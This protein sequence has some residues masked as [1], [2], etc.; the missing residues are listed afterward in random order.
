MKTK[1]LIAGLV[2]AVAFASM[3]VSV[4]ASA[5][6][7]SV[8]I[9][10]AEVEAGS[11]FT[12]SV[13]LENIPAAGINGCEFGITY[14]SSVVTV[15]SVE[16]GDLAKDVTKDEDTLPPPLEVNIEK[17]VISLM[18]ALG[19]IDSKLY[20]SGSGT[21]LNIKGEVKDTAKAGDKSVF[22]IVAVDRAV[23]PG[24]T[25]SNTDIVFG[26]VS[27]DD[28]VKMYTPTFTSGTVTV[29]GGSVETTKPTTTETPKTSD[30][31]SGV[32]T[33]P[34][35]SDN[36]GNGTTAPTTS[37]N[38]GDGTTAPGTTAKTTAKTTNGDTKPV[39]T[40]DI[41]D[42]KLYGDVNLD[43][44]VDVSDVVALNLYLLNSEKY[45]LTMEAVAN[46]DCQRDNAI[47]PVDSAVLMNAVV[48]LTDVKDLGKK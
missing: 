17:D 47:T 11:E 36:K 43:G 39:T 1:K 19:T 16:L 35:T 30:N 41:P 31:G 21:F 22:E 27:D 46:A 33:A 42:G 6:D 48:E 26:Y 8:K 13:D 18:Y 9:S 29:K 23:T 28:S 37:D 7:L 12:L 44:S 2:S 34:T 3:T 40:I 25:T 14:D 10:S 24:S 5:A 15:S 4:I 20:L 45:P 32:N 38:N